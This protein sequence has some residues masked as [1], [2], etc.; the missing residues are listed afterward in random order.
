MGRAARNPDTGLTDKEET[1]VHKIV[2]EGMSD[3]DA[4]RAA[5]K[6]GRMKDETIRKEA[7]RLKDSPHI[8]PC[9]EKLRKEAAEVTKSEGIATLSQKRE[10][11]WS[12]A[13]RCVEPTMKLI[14]RGEGVEE[15]AA[16]YDPKAAVSAIAE[17]NK[18]DGDLAA[19][20]TDN[21]HVLEYEDI[22]DEELNERIARAEKEAGVAKA[23]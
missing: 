21:R 3:T 9:I 19:I 11:L 15:F 4:Y 2:Y 1:F 13:Q 5:Y 7:A 17:L 22:T 23:P 18:M 20:K 6:T 16:V 8:A 14:G 12:I 10:M